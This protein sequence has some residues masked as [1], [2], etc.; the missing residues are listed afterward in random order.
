MAG[1]FDGTHYSHQAGGW[2][3]RT[4]SANTLEK[5]TFD[6]ARNWN[7]LLTLFRMQYKLNAD[8]SGCVLLKRG[9]AATCLLRVWVW[10]PL[11]AWMSV[12]YVC[13]VLSDRG[14][15]NELNTHPEQSYQPWRV[16]VCDLE[17]LWM[18]P[19]PNGGCCAKNKQTQTEHVVNT[20]ILSYMV[21]VTK[22]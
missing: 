1:S 12:W 13:C 10:I 5:R 21:D 6:P 14:L 4:A 8:P 17:T 2:V 19:W 22:Y 11:G 18:R 9:S 7:M 20:Y 16:V 15:C 3:G